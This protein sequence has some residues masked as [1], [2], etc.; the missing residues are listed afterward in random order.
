MKDRHTKHAESHKPP[1]GGEGETPAPAPETQAAPA[2]AAAK[3]ELDTLKDQILRLQADFDNF[4]KR[5]VREREEWSLRASADLISRLLPVIDH[6]DLGLRSAE[7]HAANPDII[8][9]LR[10]VYDQF[11]K[12]LQEAGLQPIDAEGQVFD[13]HHHEAVTHMPS[14]D[15]P[16]DTIIT[17]TRR[18]YLLGDRLLRA[19]QVVVSSGPAI[20]PSQDPNAGDPGSTG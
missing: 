15:I 17:Q 13:P 6:F 7:T 9:G 12:A 5:T 14:N 18:G 2:P 19:A 8:G 20:A 3:S 10:V 16:A 11:L 4:R 1:A